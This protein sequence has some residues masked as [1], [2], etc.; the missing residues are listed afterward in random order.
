[1]RYITYISYQS[2]EN[3]TM[4]ADIIDLA[5][6]QKAKVL[7][8]LSTP[9]QNP[10]VVEIHSRSLMALP[11]VTLPLGDCVDWGDFWKR[12]TMWNDDPTGDD[13]AD[14]KRGGQ[15]ARKAITAIIKDGARS[16][17]LEMV[18]EAIMERGFR[19][20]GPG[21]RLCRQLSSAESAFLTELC[22][23]AVEAVRQ[24][25]MPSNSHEA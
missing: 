8:G 11:F 13:H 7:H 20:R 3:C 4:T 2:K 5:T 14:Y 16:R 1:M 9:G 18:V 21:G 17:G 24:N 22:K 25:G 12:T 6:R 19:R 23:I 10:S 15:Y